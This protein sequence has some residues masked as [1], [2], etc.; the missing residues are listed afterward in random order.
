MISL[1]QSMILLVIVKDF[2]VKEQIAYSDIQL[3]QQSVNCYVLVYYESYEPKVKVFSEEG[4][5]KSVFHLPSGVS[6]CLLD[7][8]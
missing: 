2:K 1:F 7:G 4:R 3:F 6:C 8:K 5:E